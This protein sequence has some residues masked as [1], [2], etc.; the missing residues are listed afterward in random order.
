MAKKKNKK[1]SRGRGSKT[2]SSALTMT[3]TPILNNIY[4]PPMVPYVPVFGD[5]PV[6]SPEPDIRAYEPTGGT[7]TYIEPPAAAPYWRSPDAFGGIEA[8][9]I[10]VLEYK[11]DREQWFNRFSMEVKKN[12]LNWS[13]WY[14]DTNRQLLVRLSDVEGNPLEGRIEPGEDYSKLE[15]DVPMIKTNLVEIHFDRKIDI[16]ATEYVNSLRT[17][18]ALPYP[19]QVRNVLFTHEVMGRSDFP[20]VAEGEDDI[21]ITSP[22]GHIERLTMKEWEASKIIDGEDDTH[23]K[24]EPQA[25]SQAVVSCYLDITDGTGQPSLIDRLELDP[26]YSGATMNIYYS[27]DDTI[28]YD[29]SDTSTS[30]PKINYDMKEWVPVQRDYT[31]QKGIY[32]LPP[33]KAKWLKLEFTNLTP[34]PYPTWAEGLKRV[35][36][37]YP[38]WVHQWYATMSAS[39]SESAYDLKSPISYFEHIFDTQAGNASSAQTEFEIAL[40]NQT[41]KLKFFR[42]VRHEY[43]EREVTIVDQTAYFMGLREVRAFR[44]DYAQAEDTPEYVETFRDDTTIATNTFFPSD[45]TFARASVAYNP[46]T[47]AN[48][49][50]EVVRYLTGKYGQAI[51]IEEGTTNLLTAADSQSFAVAVSV[52]V[53]IGTVYTV[54]VRGTGTATLSDAGAGAASAGNSVTFTASTATLTLT[55]TGTV[56]YC[57]VEAKTQATS[58]QIGGTVRNGES[59][60]IPTAGVFNRSVWTVEGRFKTPKVFPSHIP[61]YWYLPIDG[62][63]FYAL[64]GGVSNGIRLRATSGGI[65]AQTPTRTLTADTRYYFAASGDGTTLRLRIYS[66][67]G[68]LVYDDS[69]AYTDP[70]GTL[71][72]SMNLGG[73][74]QANASYD[75]IRISNI[76]RS[77]SEVAAVAVSAFPSSVDEHTTYKIPFDNSLKTTRAFRGWLTSIAAGNTVTT[78]VL[79]SMSTFRG[80]QLAVQASHWESQ[81]A[82]N[83]MSLGNPNPDTTDT[84]LSA[85]EHLQNHDGTNIV[86]LSGSSWIKNAAQTALEWYEATDALSGEGAGNVIKMSRG[87]AANHYGIRTKPGIFTTGPV[88]APYDEAGIYSDSKSYDDINVL[89]TAGARTSAVARVYA[90]SAVNGK[91]ELRLYAGG[92][93]VARKHFTPPTQRWHEVELG[94]TAK[95][96]DT[97]FQVEIVQTDVNVDED[98]AIDFLGIFQNPVRWEVSNDGGTTYRDVLFAINNP[99]AFITFGASDKRLVV[100]ARALRAGAIVSQFVAVPWYDESPVVQRIPIDYISPWGESERDDLRATANK[101]LF[102]LWPHL[103]P[104]QFSL[105]QHGNVPLSGSGFVP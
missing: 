82:P 70:V 11:F 5:E 104:R 86:T 63:N 71:P 102:R 10:T 40:E 103:F 39:A 62:S 64:Y 4:T 23:W 91:Y 79:N 47:L 3:F 96:G 65:T 16:T 77:A 67:T 8:D 13:V 56:T 81:M 60:T 19:V 53:T 6:V 55:P 54:S 48:V 17:Q 83:T 59:L 44:V 52:A 87:T 32:H 49:A 37:D 97:D 36:K 76:A 100:R 21:F 41:Q 89:E 69:V 68:T 84:H 14:F 73:N 29:I 43:E 45:P 66:D 105:N 2:Q 74:P 30:T 58:W 31:V 85:Y 24:C 78:K 34:Q 90:L 9:T 25:T 50:S 1:K 15:F 92:V 57:Q 95:S 61:Y 27:N 72:V 18:E 28:T 38:Q 7:Y 35:V 88:A 33:L 98:L 93:M 80:L 20:V 75:D 51:F 26:L 42:T 94:Y 101:P 99:N 46:E 22:L 12:P